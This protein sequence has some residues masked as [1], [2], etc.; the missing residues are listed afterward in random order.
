[1]AHVCQWDWGVSKWEGS[2]S[3]RREAL[4]WYAWKDFLSS[5]PRGWPLWQGRVIR[6]LGDLVTGYSVRSVPCRTPAGRGG[7]TTILVALCVLSASSVRCLHQGCVV[8]RLKGRLLEEVFLFQL[9][10]TQY[11]LKEMLSPPHPFSPLRFSC[12]YIC[13]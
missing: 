8:R 13:R 3:F 5:H 2:L 6:L 10:L 12:L 9:G 4:T 1:M 11:F 7:S